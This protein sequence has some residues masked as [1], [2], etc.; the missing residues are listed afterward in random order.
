MAFKNVENLTPV[1]SAPTVSEDAASLNGGNPVKKQKA[2]RSIGGRMLRYLLSAGLLAI[3]GAAAIYA[4]NKCYDAAYQSGYDVGFSEGA[5]KQ[6]MESS[7]NY[8]RGYSL[9]RS[10]GWDVG[11]DA[12]WD[13]G[14]DSGWD[15]GWDNGYNSYPVMDEKLFEYYNTCYDYWKKTGE[16]YPGFSWTPE[17]RRLWF[18]MRDGYWPE[19]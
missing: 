7:T 14:W 13:A 9:G 11:W 10:T 6:L 12:G 5:K 17:N 3:I 18:Y 1:V 8:N 2:T 4:Y 15:S 16:Y 19:D